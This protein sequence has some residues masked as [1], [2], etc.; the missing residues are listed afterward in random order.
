MKQK[1][2]ATLLFCLAATVARAQTEFVI[3]AIAP[4][5]PAEAPLAKNGRQLEV[6]AEVQD[7]LTH[8][9]VKV[10]AAELLLASDS[11]FVDSM[12]TSFQA[13]P[14]YSSYSLVRGIVN[15]AGDYLI[16]LS[17]EGYQTAYVPLSVKKLYK[18]E[19]HRMLKTIYLKKQKKKQEMELEEV[20][21]TA[22][23]LKFYMDGDTLVY[24][25]DAF[26]M[27][28]GSMLNELIKKLPGVTLER[29]GVIKV[30]GKTVSALLLNG[31]DFFDDD[32][33]LLLENMPSYMVK[34]IQSYERV[35][36]HLK[37]TPRE[38]TAK[39][40]LVMNVKLKREYA[41]GW[42]AN[43][44]AGGGSTFSKNE[45]GKLDTKYLGR[46]FGLRFT[47]R[48]R[49]MLYANANNLNDYRAPGDEGD[50]SQLSQSQ[51]LT[52]SYTLGGN[53][54]TSNQDDSFNYQA[55]M[56]G[57]Y[58][59]SDEGSNSSG[60]TFLEGGDTYNRSSTQ[61][62][63]REW[64]MATRQHLRFRD[65]EGDGEFV[66][67]IY[68]Q[69][70]QSINYKKQKFTSLS[71]DATLTEDVA[72]QLG[73]EW[74]DSIM[75]PH[76]GNLL[77]RYV[78]NRSLLNRRGNNEELNTT[79]T[80]FLDFSPA[81][82]DYISFTLMFDHSYIKHKRKSYTHYLLDYPSSST[83]SDFRNRYNPTKDL[84]HQWSVTPQMTWALDP[85]N[86]HSISADYR[87]NYHY[88]SS[89]SPLYLLH[90]LEGWNTADTQHELGMLPSTE[91]MLSTH[92]AY[93]SS[94]SKTRV[95][96]HTPNIRYTLRMDNAKTGSYS[97]LTLG[98]SMPMRNE[99][100]DYH[101]GMQVDTLMNRN[102]MFVNAS[103]N[104]FHDIF[105]RNRSISGGY[106]I[107][108]NAPSM[109]SLLD[110][111]DDRNPLF[112]T[113]GNPNLKS[114]RT[115]RFDATYRDKFGKTFFYINVNGYITE[116]AEASGF[117][118]N[119]E[120]GVRTI[121]PDNVNGNWNMYVSSRADFALDPHEKWRLTDQ[122]SYQYSHNV[123]LS[124]TNESL[125]ATRS[126]VNSNYFTKD[127]AIDWRPT[128][129]M[130]YSANGKLTYQHSSS[131][132]EGFTDINAFTFQYGISGQIELPWNIQCSTDLTMY[133][134]RGYSEASMNT[135][136]LVWNARVAKRLMK[137]QLTIMFDGFDL[138]GN[139]SN[140]HRYINAQGR[141]ET[142]YN[143]IPSYGLFHVIWRLNKQPQKNK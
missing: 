128:D 100:M 26:S 137:G 120:T 50:W 55:N 7:H 140:V 117:I 27:A 67:D 101:R 126:V 33:E 19:R 57:S 65:Q 142:I 59:D 37:G 23:K 75:A 113:Q 35:P 139:L 108:H 94:D 39:K 81:H 131:A 118:Y 41:T 49:L 5:H 125:R 129:K 85:N 88:N 114:T 138:L 32:R 109:T 84:T 14:D 99:K 48:S 61:G 95:H 127:L 132:R 86:K 136:E 58:R 82:N 47:D 10:S 122:L 73:K 89:N 45:R 98:I 22:T 115:H 1:L 103:I 105:K 116:N 42:L 92:D 44:E 9:P 104:I 112:I 18:K 8:D 121:T 21:V 87:Y 34:H 111:R 40:E 79:T 36:E 66:K 141:S 29:G 133:S 76:G 63:D 69:A 54:Q 3:T 96:S 83:P 13:N 102:T 110:I 80:G 20:T 68:F 30:N 62:N 106:S 2:L 97:S 56:E 31:K 90:M 91:E 124:G 28:E 11:S 77:K 134:R 51:G 71:A 52:K 64:R 15:Q 143:M 72:G 135:N 12:R 25:A 60:A 78:I 107:S 46:L 123:D 119:K 17:A 74:M 4:A 24:D 70:T 38:K 16:R 43:A 93:N 53:L 6:Q 130:E